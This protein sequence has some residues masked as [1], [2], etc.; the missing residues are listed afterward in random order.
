MRRL[1]G[2]TRAVNIDRLEQ[3]VDHGI[4]QLYASFHHLDRGHRSDPGHALVVAGEPINVAER[5]DRRSLAT[6][7]KHLRGAAG[8]L[9]NLRATY[10]EDVGTVARISA[11][12][13]SIDQGLTNL[14][15]EP[16]NDQ[17]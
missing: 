10:S 2:E 1:K 5:D 13:D 4:S 15:L 12:I 9:D 8:G 3:C 14:E 17:K 7:V 6:L 16:F 11:M